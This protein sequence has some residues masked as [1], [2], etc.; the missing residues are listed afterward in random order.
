MTLKRMALIKDGAVETI[1]LWDGESL[2]EPEGYEAKV[3][4]T[5][6]DVS[7]GDL[8]NGKTFSNSTP[9]KT[10]T[11]QLKEAFSTLSVDLQAQFAT[12]A[13]AV[14]YAMKNGSPEVA[15]KI[16]ENVPVPPELEEVKN[17]LLGAFDSE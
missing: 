13:S 12:V 9:D 14:D 3:D 1:A 5:D 7:I 15:Q 2:W 17:K 10:T 11:D 16:I 6:K 4:V 8:Y